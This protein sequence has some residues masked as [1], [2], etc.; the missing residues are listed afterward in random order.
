MRRRSEIW[1]RS[2]QCTTPSPTEEESTTHP[3]T[4]NSRPRSTTWQML[5]WQVSGKTLVKSIPSAR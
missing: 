5:S 1:S 4:S 2:W 3:T